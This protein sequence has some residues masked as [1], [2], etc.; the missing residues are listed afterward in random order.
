MSVSL[1]M[2]SDSD[3]DRLAACV[4]ALKNLDVPCEARVLSAH[5]TPKRLVA[6]LE[7]AEKRGIQAYVVR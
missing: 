3:F 4:Q 1:L 2:G 7:D 5:R 6:Y